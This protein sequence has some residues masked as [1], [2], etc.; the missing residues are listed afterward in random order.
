M[1]RNY[2]IYLILV[3]FTLSSVVW[4]QTTSAK[5]NKRIGRL[6]QELNLTPAQVTKLE[7]ITA[8]FIEQGKQLKKQFQRD[9][10]GL[11]AARSQLK[12]DS[13]NRI[14]S[15][16]TEKQQVKFKEL[17]KSRRPTKQA[18][19]KEKRADKQKGEPK[20]TRVKL[21]KKTARPTIDNEQKRTKRP[22]KPATKSEK[23]SEKKP[24]KT[25]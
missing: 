22:R 16:L 19:I 15:I 23:K 25:Q 20:K 17:K 6:E 5:K 10:E 9:S 21:E 13:D 18:R 4:G 14:M 24:V 3:M 1:K 12:Q 2:I 7:Q 8:E 11:R